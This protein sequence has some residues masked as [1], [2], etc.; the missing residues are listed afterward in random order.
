MDIRA[1]IKLRKK[2]EATGCHYE[3][4]DQPPQHVSP[5]SS[6]AK[7]DRPIPYVFSAKKLGNQFA[8]SCVW[9]CALGKVVPDDWATVENMG[10]RE[11]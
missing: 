8:W 7:K 11:K 2:R 3:H 5:I 1:R 4:W 6:L 10:L 9:Y